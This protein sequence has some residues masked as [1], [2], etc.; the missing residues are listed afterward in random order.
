[1]ERGVE[2]CDL[3]HARERLAGRRD[4][5]EGSGLMAR[6]EHTGGLDVGEHLV[7]DE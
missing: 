4:A 1:M 3:G 7:V 6:R 2:A 5:R